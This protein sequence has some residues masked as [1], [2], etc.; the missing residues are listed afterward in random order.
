MRPGLA[1]AALTLAAFALRARGVRVDVVDL[2]ELF[3]I[4]AVSSPGGFGAFVAQLRDKPL[5][6]LIDPLLTYAFS[7][8]S[9]E[10]WWLR[11]QG[12]LLGAACVPLLYSFARRTAGTATA[13][14]AAALLAGSLHHVEFS[15]FLDFYPNLALWTILSTHLLASAVEDGRPRAWAAYGAALA[16]FLYTHPWAVLVAGLHG[17]WL[18]A[19]ARGRWKGFVAAATGAGVLF[20]PFFVWSLSRVVRDPAFAYSGAGHSRPLYEAWWTL[21]C[22][23]GEPERG[24]YDPGAYKNWAIL[25]GFLYAALAAAGAWRVK[26]EG[27]W[28]ARWSLAA[29]LAAVGV[30][31]VI[32]VDAAFSYDYMPR[33]GIHVLPFFLMFVAEG[34]LWRPARKAGA[35]A[36]L[37]SGLFFFGHYTRQLGK[38]RNRFLQTAALTDS[39]TRPGDTILF[40]E[41]NF[42]AW[43]LYYYDRSAFFRVGPPRLRDGFY[44]FRLPSDFEAG[45]GR[46]VAVVWDPNEETGGEARRWADLRARMKAG[47]LRDANIHF[48]LMRPQA[49]FKTAEFLAQAGIKL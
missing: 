5:H 13:L 18:A 9:V 20:L 21:R 49:R 34:L 37:L 42:A 12:V 28:N 14:A 31:I 46:K 1:V 39:G 7:R 27:R 32:L 2:H 30:P 41:P 44:V 38:M 10:L 16:C 29:L 23:A 48:S 17:A 35:A 40:D 43:F 25:A 11:L 4:H 6:V 8:V 26:T 19:A 33:Q 24:L 47:T 22:W 3:Q 36:V 45:G 15:A